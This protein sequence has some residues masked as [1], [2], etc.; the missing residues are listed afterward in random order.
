MSPPPCESA[1]RCR[2]SVD[3]SAVATIPTLAPFLLGYLAVVS[4]PAYLPLVLELVKDMDINVE[5]LATVQ[6]GQLDGPVDMLESGEDGEWSGRPGVLAE[7]SGMLSLVQSR[8][9][10][11]GPFS[12]APARLSFSPFGPTNEIV[13]HQSEKERQREMITTYLNRFH[14]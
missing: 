5:C 11:E 6:W 9:S 4:F 8:E 3:S 10:G 7:T 1:F 14:D 13:V 2:E 12:A